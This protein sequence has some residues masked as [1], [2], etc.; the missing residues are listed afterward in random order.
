VAV[1]DLVLCQ[2]TVRET[3]ARLVREIDP[4][5]VGLSVMTFQRRTAGRIVEL[6]GSLKPAVKIVVGGYDPSLAFE[7]YLSMPVDFIVRGEGEVTFRELTRALDGRRDMHFISG[8]SHRCGDKWI[9]TSGVPHRL[10]DDEFASRPVRGFEGLS[11]A[12]SLVVELRVAAPMTVVSA[13][14][15]CI[16]TLILLTAYHRHPR[17]ENAWCSIFPSKTSLNVRRFEG[18][19]MPSST[20]ARLP[21]LLRS[22]ND[23]GDSESWRDSCPAYA[24]RGVSLWE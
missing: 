16:F 6:I 20:W 11:L 24:L 2:H 7:A 18:F 9:T 3:V 10:E 22:R 21:G 15:S 8:L 14:S 1:A 5:L 19:A 13:P 12:A 4:E 23:L 17:C